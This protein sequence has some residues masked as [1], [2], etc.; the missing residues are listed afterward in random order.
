MATNPRS[1]LDRLI[2]AL[3]SFHQAATGER[4][5]GLALIW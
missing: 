1:A 2:G 4:P 5:G 3:E